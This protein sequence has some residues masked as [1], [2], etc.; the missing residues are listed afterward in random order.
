MK[1]LRFA[2]GDIVRIER[3][4]QYY[5]KVGIVEEVLTPEGSGLTGDYALMLDETRQT[6]GFH[7]EELDPFG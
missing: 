7:D 4:G 2:K 6:Y 5:G 1:A 3:E